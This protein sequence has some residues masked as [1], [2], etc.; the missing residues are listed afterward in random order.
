VPGYENLKGAMRFTPKSVFRGAYAL[1]YSGSVMQA[2]GT[3]GSSG[4]DGFTGSTGMI[5][6]TDG[7]R[8][9]QSSLSNPFPNGFN[10]PLGAMEGPI[11]GANTNLGLASGPAFSTTT[12]IL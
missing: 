7:G 3:S 4:T 11:S 2:A 9:I 6:S 5:V 1:M 10:F 12:A 8:T